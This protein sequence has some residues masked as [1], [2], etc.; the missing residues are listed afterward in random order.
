MRK[1][2]KR[3]ERERK[4][5]D[6]EGIDRLQER[7]GMAGQVEGKWRRNMCRNSGKTRVFQQRLRI[8]TLRSE[9]VKTRQGARP[10]MRGVL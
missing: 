10:R 5:K 2:R 1:G 9:R 6:E 8:L 7:Q 3:T 4:D